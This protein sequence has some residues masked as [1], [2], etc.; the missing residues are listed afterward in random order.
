[1][2]FSIDG[3]SSLV[4]N[5]QNSAAAG[6][7]SALK[8]SIS[9]VS[10][11][12]SEE[13]LLSVCK[14]FES[15]FVEEVLKEVKENLISDDDED[16]DKDSSLSTLTDFHMDSTIE[17]LADEIVDQVGENYTQQLYEQMK[18]NYGIE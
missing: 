13:E 7:A 17:L 4:S 18:R 10:S 5:A 2:S 15:Y 9:G 11:D 3:I 12:S 8:N 6:S 1:M 16:K 14:D